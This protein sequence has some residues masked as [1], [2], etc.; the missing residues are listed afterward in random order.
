[1]AARNAGDPQCAKKWGVTLS[2]MKLIKLAR[3]FEIF[4]MED[5][6]AEL[7]LTHRRK[8][9]ARMDVQRSLDLLTPAWNGE[10]PNF[11]GYHRR[12]KKRIA[13]WYPR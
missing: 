6:A 7:L 9:D 13:E 12:F 5:C 4:G 8:L 3:I 11:L 1:M 10:K 2:P